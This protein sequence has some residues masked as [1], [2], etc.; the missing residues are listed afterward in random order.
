MQRIVA[1]L[2]EVGV[3]GDQVLHVGDLA[4]QDDPIPGQAELL[5]TLRA[6]E[7]RDDQRVAHHRIR[8]PGLAAR[9]VGVHH[10]REQRRVEAAPVDADAHRLVELDRLFDQHGEL[11]IALVPLADVAGIDA[12]LGQRPRALRVLG[13]QLVAVEVEVADQR[14]RAT[15]R[16][17]GGA[18]RRHGRSRL[19]GVHGDADD[20]GTGVGERLHLRGRRGDVGGVGVGHR[21]HQHGRAA[22]DRVAG[23]VDLPGRPARVA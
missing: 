6:L 17:E 10:P 22:A 8:G 20:L 19:G 23:D 13:Q 1:A 4:G 7:R 5:G 18:D 15:L 9:G 2:R 3:N 16:V 14:H 21:L 12:E 11:R